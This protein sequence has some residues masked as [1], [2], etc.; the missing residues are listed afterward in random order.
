MNLRN[1]LTQEIF[2]EPEERKNV[3]LYVEA[4]IECGFELSSGKWV[5]GLIYADEDEKLDRDWETHS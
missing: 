5:D 3:S 4:Q 2:F 1:V